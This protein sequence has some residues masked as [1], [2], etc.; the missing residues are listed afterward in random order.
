MWSEAVCSCLSRAEKLSAASVRPGGRWGLCLVPWEE[1]PR[2][3]WGV[4]IHTAVAVETCPPSAWDQRCVMD[5]P[6]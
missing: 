5:Q 4:H 2:G 3:S 6:R 1:M